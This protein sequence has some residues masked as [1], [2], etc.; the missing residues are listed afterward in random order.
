MH[1]LTIQRSYFSTLC[2]KIHH[3]VEQKLSI[4]LVLSGFGLE[5]E[6]FGEIACNGQS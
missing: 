4:V 5:K 2:L 1:M 3:V 6:F